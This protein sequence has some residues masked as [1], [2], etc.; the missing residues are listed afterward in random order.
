MREVLGERRDGEET[1]GGKEIGNGKERHQDREGGSKK[2]KI[3]LEE[4]T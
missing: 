2:K 3:K 1:K 4:K